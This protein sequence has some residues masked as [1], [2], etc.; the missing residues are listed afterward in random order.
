MTILISRTDGIGDVVLTLPL[1]GVIKHCF[2][3]VRV[4]FLGRTYTQAVVGMCGDVDEFLNWDELAKDENRGG[5][6]LKAKQIDVV[7]HVF[8]NKEVAKLCKQAGIKS[9]VGTSHRIYNWL[10]CNKL[11]HFSRRNSNEHEAVLNLKLLYPLTK[12]ES[13]ITVENICDY[14]HIKAVKV[15]SCADKL[16]ETSRYFKLILHPK[17]K[18]SAREWGLHNFRLLIEALDK[19]KFRIFLCGT[20]E[21]GQRF[22]GELLSET[23]ENVYD[24]SGKLSLEQ[25]ICLIADSDALVAA[26]TGPLHIAAVLNRHAIGL[27]PPI[28]PMNP[29]RW[30]PI[31]R[32]VKVFCKDKV[33]NSCRKTTYCSCMQSIKPKEVAEYLSNLCK[34]RF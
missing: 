23:D 16:L 15:P 18:G 30:Q 4:L 25:Y 7:L 32:K 29:E 6:I 13:R 2:A 17:S 11:V 26:S 28:R 31:G 20:E 9:R 10:F 8:P 33:C 3:D 14:V 19:T 24:L 27:Y 34:E 21:E 22:R 5:K 12:R 1:A